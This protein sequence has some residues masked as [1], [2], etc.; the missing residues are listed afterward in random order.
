MAQPLMDG[1]FIKVAYQFFGYGNR[2]V[3][4]LGLI[5]I[6]FVEL[7]HGIQKRY[8]KMVFKNGILKW[9]PKMAS[10]NDI[11]KRNSKDS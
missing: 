11:P 3:D 1:H 7:F 4:Y 10:K 5:C 6:E 9:Y 2:L 8:P